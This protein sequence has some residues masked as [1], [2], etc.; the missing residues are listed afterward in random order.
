MESSGEPGKIQVS[1]EFYKH[2][3]ED[4]QCEP[5][6]QIEIKGKGP[7]NLYFLMKR[8][9]SAIKSVIDPVKEFS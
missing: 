8:K 9:N 4:Y 2:I 7:M 1:E 3:K 6:G 5:R